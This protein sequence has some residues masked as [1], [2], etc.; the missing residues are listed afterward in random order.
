MDT[1]STSPEDRQMAFLGMG[2]FLVMNIGCLIE[3]TIGLTPKTGA[4][5]GIAFAAL[6]LYA[7]VLA[8]DRRDRE[9]DERNLAV[10]EAEFAAE[11]DWIAQ[12]S[13][14]FGNQT[15]NN[16][17]NGSPEGPVVMGRDFGD[18]HLHDPNE[19]DAPGSRS[20]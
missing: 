3:A 11:R 18:V 12:M 4:I 14:L 2:F 9:A 10:Q 19:N 13:D 1:N 5:L 6:L 20:R 7:A 15:V 8:Q 16:T 17:I